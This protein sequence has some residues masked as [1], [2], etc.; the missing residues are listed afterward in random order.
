MHVEL[1]LLEGGAAQGLLAHRVDQGLQRAPQ[2]RGAQAAGPGKVEPT[3]DAATTAAPA[4][5]PI[6][7]STAQHSIEC[8]R[9]HICSLIMQTVGRSWACAR[10]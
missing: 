7:G 5:H 9:K 1:H 2:Q 4:A 8:E 3:A 6:G 10:L